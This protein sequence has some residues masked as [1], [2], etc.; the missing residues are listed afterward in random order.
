MGQEEVLASLAWKLLTFWR[1]SC[2]RGKFPFW[3]GGAG[4]RKG[5]FLR[6]Q[7]VVDP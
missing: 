1:V 4:E 6:S 5:D 7:I 2:C 3:G